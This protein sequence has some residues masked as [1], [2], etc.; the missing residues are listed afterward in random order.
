MLTDNQRHHV[1]NVL[2]HIESETQEGIAALESDDPDALFPRYRDFPAASDIARLRS[3]LARMR[4][5][6]RR[7]LE[8][9]DIAGMPASTI[10]ASWAF[11]TRMALARHAAFE[12]AP[13]HLR[14][15]G[16]LDAQGEGDCRA[17]MAE[18]GLLLDDIANE[19]R[20]QPLALPPDMDSESLLA[21]IVEVIEHHHLLELRP[22]A[23]DLLVAGQGKPRVEVA[24]LGRVS[25][26][27]SSLVNALLGQALLPVG[28]MP[29][30]AVVTRVQYGDAARV[31]AHDVEGRSW[32]IPFDQLASC[33]T[34]SGGASGQ[35]QLREVVVDLPHPMLRRGMVLTDTPG[36][37]SLH[38]R[39][40]AHA[41]TYVPRCD[42]G[43]LAVDA[44]ATLQA[45]DIDLAQALIQ[46]HASCLLVLT[47][48]DAVTS[49]AL[50]QQRG[51]VERALFQALG[52]ALPVSEVS[53]LADERHPL[54]AWKENVLRPALERA[55][56]QGAQRAH[57]RLVSLG[58]RACLLLEQAQGEGVA[59]THAAHVAGG[60]LAALDEAESSLR[61]LVGDLGLRG[62]SVV[63]AEALPDAVQAAGPVGPILSKAA[64][65]LADEVVRDMTARLREVASSLDPDALAAILR[66]VP[67]FAFSPSGEPMRW[68]W[69]GFSPWTRHRWK[70]LLRETY[71]E[72]LQQAFL[73]YGQNLGTWLQRAVLSLRMGLGSDVLTTVPTMA[74]GQQAASDLKRLRRLLGEESS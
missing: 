25:S 29:V 74:A 43:I 53:V 23:R 46:A 34:E 51:Y 49:D 66:G 11:Q 39:A 7:F 64:A 3:H 37:G 35:P 12:L 40:S 20:R 4:S 68:P 70:I 1:L 52:M 67:P 63:L 5:V 30:T 50:E 36:L 47:K 54:A 13:G 55:A 73:A 45:Q 27:K 16:P 10:D 31:Q 41:L 72:P 18:L 33:I 8:T 71:A 22:V 57:A 58:R 19:L 62:A 38:P 24:V 60:A 65:A 56:T 6:M 69:Q 2:R 15:Y 21:A 9:Q 28:A 44:T 48:A 32:D 42:L 17:L 61:R 26:G 14:G 59:I